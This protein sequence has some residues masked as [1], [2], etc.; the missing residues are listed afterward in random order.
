MNQGLVILAAWSELTV[1]VLV[2][3]YWVMRGRDG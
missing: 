1:V 2:L 3:A